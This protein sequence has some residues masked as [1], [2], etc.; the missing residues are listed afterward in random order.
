MCRNI[1]PSF[2]N[3]TPRA[4]APSLLVATPRACLFRL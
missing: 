1:A 4:A 3:G 2:V